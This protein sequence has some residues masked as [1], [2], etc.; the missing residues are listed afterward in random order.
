[1]HCHSHIACSVGGFGRES[2]SEDGGFDEDKIFARYLL[3]GLEEMK[4]IRGGSERS[5]TFA[6]YLPEGAQ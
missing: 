1:M 4:K 3:Y 6:R 5:F 2:V